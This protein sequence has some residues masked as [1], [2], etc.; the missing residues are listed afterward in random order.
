M[1]R[2]KSTVS[3]TVIE[4]LSVPPEQQKGTV[5]QIEGRGGDTV[6]NRNGELTGFPDGLSL[7]NI[8]YAPPSN[9]SATTE[10]N[11]R[12]IQRAAREAL[13]TVEL[14]IA[15]QEAIDAA[16]PCLEIIEIAAANNG[17]R[18][19]SEQIAIAKDKAFG[20]TINNLADAIA[21]QE[22]FLESAEGLTEMIAAIV[23]DG[24]IVATKEDIEKAVKNG[25]IADNKNK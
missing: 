2:Q 13:K 14:F 18:L 12:P 25:T 6:Q 19:S 15:K 17:K 23:R 24:K 8:V 3:Y 11:L 5:I 21:A 16:T 22:S 7:E 10:E 4:D 20:K 1:T 9:E